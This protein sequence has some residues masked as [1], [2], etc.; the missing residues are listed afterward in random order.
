MVEEQI[1]QQFRRGEPLPVIDEDDLHADLRQRLL[2]V[3]VANEQVNILFQHFA[4]EVIAQQLEWLPHRNANNPARY[5]IAAI[6]GDYKAPLSVRHRR[7]VSEDETASTNQ[8]SDSI[9]PS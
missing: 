8:P 6:Q 9:P 3:G 7:T 4:P 5:L 1:E 2:A